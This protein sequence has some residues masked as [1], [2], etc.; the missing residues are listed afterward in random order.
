MTLQTAF[1]DTERPE[2]D[3]VE[4]SATAKRGLTPAAQIR[5]QILETCGQRGRQTYS[6]I[7]A[8]DLIGRKEYV[9]RSDGEWLHFLSLQLDPTVKWVDF[10]PRAI[11][12]Y[13]GEDH[14]ATQFD[15]VVT[16]RDG[17]VECREVKSASPPSTD[18]ERLRHALQRSAQEKAAA[19]LRGTYR[20]ITPED[21][22]PLA[23]RI[24]NSM[25]LCRYVAA[26]RDR[27]MEVAGNNVVLQLRRLGAMPLGL[28]AEMAPEGE[29]ALAVAATC[30]LVQRGVVA[31]DLD[32]T[33]V[34]FNSV[35][36][37]RE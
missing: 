15:A 20:R 35:V 18:E 24:H 10:A 34:T 8:Y 23:R 9:F 16:F 13:L 30:V 14:Y 17:R 32:R 7:L 21:L 5:Q 6:L 25:R 11:P 36:R 4:I 37:I 33:E 31:L 3:T 19:G 28:I 12:V 26:N 1:L 29:K 22:R 2:P 27:P